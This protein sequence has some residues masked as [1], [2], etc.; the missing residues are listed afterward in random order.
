M[1]VA[2][3]AAA[4]HARS[5]KGPVLVEAVTYRMGPHT[6]SDDPSIYRKD[7]EVEE[8]AKKDPIDRFKAY[9]IEKK[10]LTEKEDEALEEEYGK[11]VLESFKHVENTG[12]VKLEDIFKYTYE[13]MTPQLEE[14]YQ[15]MKNF[16]EKEGGK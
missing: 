5:G 10:Y 13:K 9:L 7:S 2:V 8:W 3:K 16:I 6:T 1:Y 11:H 14:Q 12:E 15:Q 4:D